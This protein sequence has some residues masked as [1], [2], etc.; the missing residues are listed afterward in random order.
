[1][2]ARL[3]AFFNGLGWGQSPAPAR[4]AVTHVI[5]LDGTMSSTE[6]GEETNA[7]LTWRLLREK[8]PSVRMSLFY[9]PGIQWEDWRSAADVAAGRGINRQIRRAYG[10]LA[11]RYRPGDRIYLFGYSRG[12]YAVRSLAGVIDRVGLLRAEAATERAVREAWRLYENGD[13]AEESTRARAAF[14][15]RLCHPHVEIEMIG[16]WD[17]VKALG[18]RLPLLWRVS[19]DPHNFHG[20]ELSEVVRHGFHALARDETRQAY[21]PVLWQ[22]DPDW[23]GRL[24]QVWFRGTHGDVGGQLNGRE[25]ARPLANIP[26]VWMLEHAENCGLDLPEEWRARFPTDPAAPSAGL[27]RGWSRVFLA[28]KPRV[29]GADP[30]ESLHPTAKANPQA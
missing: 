4:G 2:A 30:S 17:T 9:E 20:T 11:S 19:E 3:R 25:E 23:K 18:L 13:S 6:P 14:R 15:E 8:A 7:G 29:I 12:A 5:I 26:L 28:R 24:E 10:F 21:A 16:V 1:V 22:S 27:R